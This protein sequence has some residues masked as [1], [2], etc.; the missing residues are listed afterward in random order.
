MSNGEP[1]FR[2]YDRP[3][4]ANPVV[5]CR[6]DFPESVSDIYHQH[7]PQA[8]AAIADLNALIRRFAKGERLSTEVF[9]QEGCGY[10]FRAWRVRLYGVFS[11]RHPS[12]FVLSHAVLK[13]AQKLDPGDEDRMRRCLK[14][15]DAL[16]YPPL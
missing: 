4:G 9:R 3:A 15:F 10:A 7:G 5:Y 6:S 14:M 1:Q 12:C 2:P 13:R 11:G 8:R 16:P